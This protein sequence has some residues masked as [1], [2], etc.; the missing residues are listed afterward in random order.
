MLLNPKLE[1]EAWKILLALQA[2]GTKY[3][4]QCNNNYNNVDDDDDILSEA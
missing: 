4:L 2:N 1:E 3:K